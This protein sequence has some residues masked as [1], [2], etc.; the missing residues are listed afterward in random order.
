MFPSAECWDTHQLPRVPEACAFFPESQKGIASVAPAFPADK[1]RA[2]KK[3]TQRGCA[4]LV[5]VAN[6]ENTPADRAAQRQR[7]HF[8]FRMLLD[9]SRFVLRLR[10]MQMMAMR[11]SN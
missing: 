5:R 8:Y 1:Y 10:A 11:V 2:S 6:M 4:L 9:C 3:A 7:S